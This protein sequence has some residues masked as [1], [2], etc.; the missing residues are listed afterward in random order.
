MRRRTHELSIA[1][2][3]ENIDNRHQVAME[4][5]LQQLKTLKNKSAIEI[6]RLNQIT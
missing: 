2:D 4:N 3:H 5:R 1:Q 6:A